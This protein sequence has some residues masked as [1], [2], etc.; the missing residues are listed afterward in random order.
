MAND[1]K[2]DNFGIPEKSMNDLIEAFQSIADT[3]TEILNSQQKK[4]TLASEKKAKASK[5]DLVKVG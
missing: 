3:F 1:P 2:G 4:P 5:E